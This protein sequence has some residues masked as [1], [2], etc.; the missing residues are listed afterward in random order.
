[1]FFETIIQN[2][3]QRTPSVKSF[4]I[5]LPQP[6]AFK[7][8][9]F[10]MATIRVDGKEDSKYF[11]VSSPPT[12]KKFIEFTKRITQSPFS[13]TLDQMKPG[14]WVKVSIPMGLFTLERADGKIAFLSGG[15][16]ITPIRSM[17]Q[18]AA[19]MKMDRDIVLLYG[20]HDQTDIPFQDEFENMKKVL[21]RL[22]V[23]HV[24]DAPKE[25]WQGHTGY[26]TKEIIAQE[27]PDFAGRTFFVCGPPKMVEGLT[28][29]LTDDL[30]LSK[31]QV[32]IENFDGY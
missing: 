4:Q 18:F 25:G 17:C 1:M 19:D 12:E 22:R 6:V 16:G 9:Q 8:G 13:Q 7:A 10:M 32:I 26:M 31:K 15:I 21:P 20:N 3:I 23:V 2:I 24:L 30:Q 11:T 29:I 5:A 14:D 28:R 27:I